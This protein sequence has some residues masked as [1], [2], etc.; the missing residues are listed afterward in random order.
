MEFRI[1]GGLDL[2]TPPSSFLPLSPYSVPNAL[3]PITT[4][5]VLFDPAD[6]PEHR[7]AHD[8]QSSGH[9]LP[10][11]QQSAQNAELTEECEELIDL[12]QIILALDEVQRLLA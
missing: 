8:A 5:D 4:N 9:E 3:L 11:Q 10:Q 1:A 7:C 2:E 6:G 12:V